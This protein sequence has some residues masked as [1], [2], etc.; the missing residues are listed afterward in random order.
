MPQLRRFG[1]ATKNFC[2]PKSEAKMRERVHW[3]KINQRSSI[4]WAQFVEGLNGGGV[5]LTVDGLK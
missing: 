3:Q 4:T 1:E 5:P 2:P